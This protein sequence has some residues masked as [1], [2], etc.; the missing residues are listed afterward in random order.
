MNGAADKGAM[1]VGNMINSATV[2][3]VCIDVSSASVACPTQALPTQSSQ[4]RVSYVVLA[5]AYSAPPSPNHVRQAIPEQCRTS[6]QP[7]KPKTPAEMTDIAIVN[8]TRSLEPKFVTFT[9]R[10]RACRLLLLQRPSPVLG[11]S[12]PRQAQRK[13]HHHLVAQVGCHPRQRHRRSGSCCQ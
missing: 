7:C 6:R 13:C 9:A 1:Q 2:I 4:N 12:A 3:Y 8:R 11:G 5:N 10:N